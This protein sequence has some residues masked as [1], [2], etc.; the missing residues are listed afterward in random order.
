MTTSKDHFNIKI[1]LR[2]PSYSA[3]NISESLSLKPELSHAVGHQ[4]PGTLRAKW[5]FFS[6]CLQEGNDVADLEDALANVTF[7]L[8]KNAPF[9]TQFIGGNGDVEL[10]LNHTIYPQEEEG[11]KCF[12]LYL[13]AA[14]LGNL[15][16]RGIGLRVQGW[17]GG[18]QT[19]EF[20]L[21]PEGR[22]HGDSG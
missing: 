4:G 11:D 10:I 19:T 7:F 12:E 9:W 17:Q 18:I 2:H 15:S 13:T 6:A 1:A 14:F 8:E 20:A 5:N 3:E 21:R 22:Q 16:A